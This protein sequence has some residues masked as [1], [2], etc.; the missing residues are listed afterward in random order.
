[1]AYELTVAESRERDRIA[2]ELHDGI[3]QVLAVARFRLGELR[4]AGAERRDALLNEVDDLLR[5]ATRATR[6]TTFELG[7]PALRL[8]LHE[9]M[10]SLVERLNK[11]PG[12]RFTLEGRLP[13]LPWP[14][15]VQAVLLRVMR[16]L[17]VNVQRHAYA[18]HTTLRLSS[19]T[20]HIYVEVSDDGVGID[21]TQPLPRLTPHGGFGLHSAQA[22]VRA[23]G[24]TL[25]L[26]SGRGAGC[27]ATVTL[28]L[29]VEP[30]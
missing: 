6:S 20:T 8:G 29:A 26:E 21:P 11:S 27:T 30:A 23:L 17:C 4:G 7:T 16:E 12:A 19:D 9:A 5:D 3:G 14:D 2:R 10:L 1:L 15:E 25:L 13:D 24:G 18:R 28:P 22:Q